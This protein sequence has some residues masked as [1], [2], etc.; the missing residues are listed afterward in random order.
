MMLDSDFNR[1]FQ[2]MRAHARAHHIPVISDKNA[3]FLVQLLSQHRFMNML[4]IGSATGVSSAVIGQTLAQWGARLTTIEISV[5][6]QLAAQRNLAALGLHNVTSVCGDARQWLGQW[7]G[8][9]D[10][11][12]IDAHKSQTHVFYHAALTVLAPGGMVIVDDVWQFRRKMPLFYTALAQLKQAYCL[13][14]VD[15]GDAT[16]VIRP[17][18][19]LPSTLG[20]S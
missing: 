7:E 12:F 14:F 3:A 6:T 1:H 2:A 15:A 5:P 19:G 8:Q 13:H 17:A 10:C 20:Q 16:M 18:G 4:E 9:F 11:I